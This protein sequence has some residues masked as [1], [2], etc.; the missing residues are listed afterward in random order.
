VSI[1]RLSP[2]DS[3][4]T[5]TD[6]LHQTYAPLA[7]R[8]LRFSATHQSAEVTAQRIRG[9]VCLVAEH[10]GRLIGTITVSPHDPEDAAPAY[11]EPGIF[12]FGQFAVAPDWK[13][14]GLGRRLHAAAV[15]LVRALGGHALLLDTAAPATDL[16][17]MYE[18]WGYAEIGRT[19]WDDTNYESVILRLPL[20]A[21]SEGWPFASRALGNSRTLW[22]REPAPRPGSATPP[23]TLVF[24]DGEFYRERI[25]AEAILDDLEAR[26]DIPPTRALFISMQS[27][28]ARWI[29]CPCHPPFARFVLD[30]V[31]SWLALLHPD[32]AR[33]GVLV[34]AGLS[35]TGLAAVF[36]ASEPDSPFATVIAQSGSFWWREGWLPR[37][38]AE[39]RRHSRAR[40][41]LDVGDRET[42]ARVVHRPDVVQT[43]SQV[44]GVR[45]MRDALSAT[46]HDVA[47]REFSG[48]H[49]FPA[50][51]SALPAWLRQL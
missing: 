28:D 20:L 2:A 17:A 3:L 46:N 18:R 48:G 21:R 23:R 49:E 1:R 16:I 11:R 15:D 43:L 13:G 45:R 30:E 38:F 25:L 4:A 34:L 14:R 27:L 50:W 32:T 7:A 5:L 9:G 8:G 6:L 44:E 31:L 47:Y 37:E 42:A 33:P 10:R 19:R 35:Y 41:F 36:I 51:A 26:G 22:L 12:N 29:E 40:F 39:G 24:L